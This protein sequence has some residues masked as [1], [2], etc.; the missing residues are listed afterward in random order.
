[1]EAEY[2]RR[3]EDVHTAVKKRLVITPSS[4]FTLPSLPFPFL[5]PLHPSS[6]P[7]DAYPV[8]QGL[9]PRNQKAVL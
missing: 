9:Q 1:M 3:L 7:C 6:F 8:S 4:F 2:R 5:F